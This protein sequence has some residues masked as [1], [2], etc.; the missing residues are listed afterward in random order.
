I[1]NAAS[2]GAEFFD[3]RVS[4]DERGI[5][6]V[7]AGGRIPEREK[8]ARGRLGLGAQAEVGAS[9]FLE[10]RERIA[11]GRHEDEVGVSRDVRL[12]SLAG[13]VAGVCEPR[14]GFGVRA[15]G[16][17]GRIRGA[18]SRRNS[19]AEIS[20]RSAGTR[21]RWMSIRRAGAHLEFS[22]CWGMD[23]NGLP[24]DSRRCRDLS[25]LNSIAGIRRISS[26]GN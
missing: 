19:G 24:R 6:E 25:R 3:Q 13:I 11:G 8:L 20:T 9:A 21:P 5:F 7:R 17:S 26:T 2:A 14:G 4:G 12:D 23:G 16:A 10:A 18:R 15:M 22:I 1:W